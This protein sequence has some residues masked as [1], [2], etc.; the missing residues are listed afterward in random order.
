MDTIRNQ[1]EGMEIRATDASG[2]QQ[3]IAHVG[4]T[5]RPGKGFN[6]NLDVFNADMVAE[7]ADMVKENVNAF[8]AEAM[9]KAAAT[10]IPVGE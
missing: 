8:F 2:N 4:Y 1:S 10:G 5:I 6:V 7:N 9:A 3:S